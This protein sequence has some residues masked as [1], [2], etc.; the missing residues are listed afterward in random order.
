[1][2]KIII[3]YI[4]ALIIFTLLEIFWLSQAAPHIYQPTLSG[5]MASQPNGI[6][7]LIFFL[8]YPM[9]ILYF[10]LQ[11]DSQG[12]ADIR[13]A[14]TRGAALGLI[15]YGTYSLTNL[16]TLQG[17]TPIITMFDLGWGMTLSGLTAAGTAMMMR[18]LYTKK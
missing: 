6:A 1:M 7:G 10:T 2:K 18:K 8:F 13:Y 17:W 16:A 5:I 4:I 3:S 14:L 12:L 9:G 15:A 11:Y